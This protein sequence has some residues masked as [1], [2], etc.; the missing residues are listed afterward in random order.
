MRPAVSVILLTV[1][2][3]AG[4]GVFLALYASELAGLV[5]P[6][7]RQFFVYGSLAA[8]SLLIAGLIASFF[9]LGRPERAW[10]AAAM[11]RTSWLS[12]EVIAL[13][14]T[15]LLI[16]L[17]AAA[18]HFGVGAVTPNS[19]SLSIIVG[20][21]G[22]LSAIALFICTGM[23]YACIK[24]LQEWASPWTVINYTLMGCASGF[25]LATVHAARYAPQATRVLAIAAVCLTLLALLTRAWS[26]LR[27][28]GVKP[29]ANLQS[30]IGIRH[31]KIS[32]QTVGFMGGSFNTR[33]FFHGRTEAALN[34][35]RWL[36]LVLAFCIPILLLLLS[37]WGAQPRL[38]LLWTAFVCQFC[39]LLFERWYFFAQSNHP[40]NLYY[41]VSD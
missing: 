6:P 3:G 35:V 12:R 28:A 9:H 16:L 37:I 7:A 31:S 11:W 27:N 10:R 40:Q 25:T 15:M 23:V 13:P 39:G 20:A 33:E 1:L 22:A 26:L 5:T 38:G 4:Q 8:L 18:H 19:S 30:A 32:Q 21:V 34:T 2:I 29:R 24:F 36:F 14:I 17:Y 41:Q